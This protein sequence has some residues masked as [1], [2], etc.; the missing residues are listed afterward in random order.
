MLVYGENSFRAT[1]LFLA[2]LSYMTSG[3]NWKEGWAFSPCQLFSDQFGF[4]QIDYFKL[5]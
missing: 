5:S 1:K 4:H 2:A 3:W